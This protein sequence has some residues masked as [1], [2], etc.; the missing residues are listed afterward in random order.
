MFTHWGGDIEWLMKDL[1]YGLFYA[2]DAVLDWV[3]SELMVFTSIICQG[4]HLTIL[5]HLEGLKRMGL[6][7]EE[8]QGVVD[9]AKAVAEWAGQDV[10]VWKPVHEYLSWD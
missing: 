5:N 3:E 9:C 10:S 6:K 8:A 2:D 4:F 1:V 7:M